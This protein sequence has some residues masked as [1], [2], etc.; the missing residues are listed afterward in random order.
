MLLHMYR[1][2][3]APAGQGE[4]E[5]SGD[6]PSA[7]DRHEAGG[8]VCVRGDGNTARITADACRWPVDVHLWGAKSLSRTS[9]VRSGTRVQQ[10]F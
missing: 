7:V 9:C 5:A 6:R 4:L 1:M 3:G 10:T 8:E 2:H